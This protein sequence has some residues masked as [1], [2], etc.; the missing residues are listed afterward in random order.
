MQ[1]ALQAAGNPREGHDGSSGKRR[2]YVVHGP[3]VEVEGVDLPQLE[4]EL[5]RTLGHFA[6][7]TCAWPQG[8]VPTVGIIKSYDQAEVVRHLSPTARAVPSSAQ[9]ASGGGAG[10]ELY[11]EGERYWLIDDRWGMAEVNLLKG[12]WRSWVLPRPRLDPY[13]CAEWAA[14]WPLAQLLRS[15]GV[16]LAPAAAVVRDGWAALL[17]CPYSLEPELASLIRRGYKVIGQRWT[18]LREEDGQVA[19]MHV[20]GRV[21]RAGGSTPLRRWADG[22]GAAANASASSPSSAW[23]DLH[24][25]YPGSWQNHAFCD[26]V[27]V[28]EPG[29]RP[30]ASSRRLDPDAAAS[31][32]R[33]TWPIADLHP[34]QRRTGQLAARLGQ[35]A[36]VAQAQLSRDANDLP[37]LLDALRRAAHGR[38]EPGFAQAA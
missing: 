5:A 27:V 3:P 23:I 29:R 35:T 12:Q 9:L 8:F 20:P 7:G 33:Q 32:L 10:L 6:V 15:R 22:A 18:A 16:S 26:A 28:I 21:E 34:Q 38:S 31:L 19:L 14:L 17:L 4:G 37:A 11:A 13:E 36:H 1:H 24:D 25:Q 2:R 30:R